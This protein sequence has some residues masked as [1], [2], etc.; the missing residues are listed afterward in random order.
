MVSYFRKRPLFKRAHLRLVPPPWLSVY[1]RDLNVPVPAI[2]GPSADENP[3]T[4]FSFRAA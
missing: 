2:Y 3:F 1:L 4:T